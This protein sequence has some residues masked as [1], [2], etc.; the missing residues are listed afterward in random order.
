MSRDTTG[1][2]ETHHYLAILGSLEPETLKPEQDVC[3]LCPSEDTCWCFTLL[4][5]R[6]EKAVLPF[7]FPLVLPRETAVPPLSLWF[8]TPTMCYT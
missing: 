2:A 7:I 5:T 6:K 8:G 4:A 3:W 1:N